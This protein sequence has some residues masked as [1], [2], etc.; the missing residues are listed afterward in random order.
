VFGADQ[1]QRR[2]DALGD[3]GRR[4]RQV[5]GREADFALDRPVHRLRLRVLEHESDPPRE[6]TRRSREHVG[7]YHGDRA[8][9][10]A[11]VEVRHQSVEQAKQRRLAAAAG[12]RHQGDPGADVEIHVPEGAGTGG[13]VIVGQPT[14]R[15][16]GHRR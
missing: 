5:F 14:K 16:D 9:D 7:A 8:R 3:L 11:A 1:L 15:G 4:Q 6:V 13:R 2:P 10:A 12:A